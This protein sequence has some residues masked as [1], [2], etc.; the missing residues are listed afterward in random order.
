MRSVRANAFGVAVLLEAFASRASAGPVTSCANFPDVLRARRQRVPSR[1]CVDARTEA[2][3]R[4]PRQHAPTMFDGLRPVIS[5]AFSD[6]LH[7]PVGLRQDLADDRDRRVGQVAALLASRRPRRCGGRARPF[8]ESARAMILVRSQP[9]PVL[10]VR[11]GGG[12]ARRILR[13]S[14]SARRGGPPSRRGRPGRSRDHQRRRDVPDRRRSSG[15]LGQGTGGVPAVRRLRAPC[16]GRCGGFVAGG[17]GSK[18][19]AGELGGR[20]WGCRLVG[21]RPTQM[22]SS[23]ASRASSAAFETPRPT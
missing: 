18:S 20:R 22:P 23:Q 4:S 9:Y 21:S 16:G 2:L 3:S 13:R 7:Q 14:L 11:P 1:L 6:A 8:A 19:S 12:G 5:S 10:L 17:R 15:G